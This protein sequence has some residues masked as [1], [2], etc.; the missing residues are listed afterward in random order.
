MQKAPWTWKLDE[1]FA[2]QAAKAAAWI[3]EI[4]TQMSA[5]GWSEK[6]QLDVHLCLEEALMNAIKHGNSNDPKK[7]VFLKVWLSKELLRIEIN[8]EGPGFDIDDVPDPCCAENLTKT[9]GRGLMLLRHYMDVV[10][11]SKKGNSLFLEKKN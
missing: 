4:V 1:Q 6:L 10:Q 2:S 9:S 8:D 5:A 7:S 11:Y 3:K